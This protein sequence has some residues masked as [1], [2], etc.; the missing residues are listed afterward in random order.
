MYKAAKMH[1]R[2][3]AAQLWLGNTVP[4]KDWPLNSA[5]VIAQWD[6]ST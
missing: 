4:D 2:E 1:L 5:H 3:R 6:T